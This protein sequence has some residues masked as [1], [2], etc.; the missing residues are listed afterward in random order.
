MRDGQE[1]RRIALPGSRGSSGCKAGAP[2]AFW[3]RV[4]AGCVSGE[5]SGIGCRERSRGRRK[6]RTKEEKRSSPPDRSAASAC[7]GNER[8]ARRGEGAVAASGEGVTAP[9]RDTSPRGEVRRP[10]GGGLGTPRHRRRTGAGN[11]DHVAHHRG[12]LSALSQLASPAHTT[13]GPTSRLRCRARARYIWRLPANNCASLVS[14]WADS[15]LHGAPAA[16][17]AMSFRP[18]GTAI[19]L[20]SGAK[21]SPR[22][23]DHV[24]HGAVAR[25]EP[26]ADQA[27][28]FG[29]SLTKWNRPSRVGFVALEM[30]STLPAVGFS[31]VGLGDPPC[32]AD[33]A[34]CPFSNFAILFIARAGGR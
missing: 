33:G 26:G 9:W 23:V 16:A 11:T 27:R 20:P 22:P 28:F 3:G 5:R 4:V 8:D 15:D 24:I 17:G 21:I 6:R 31:K 1:F 10:V 25:I 34:G 30:L 13:V 29:P 14:S 18:A 19:S 32:P 7:A 12:Q 2:C